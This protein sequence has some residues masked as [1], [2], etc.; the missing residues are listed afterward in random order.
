MNKFKDGAILFAPMDGLTDPEYR[1]LILEHF[2]QWDFICTEFLRLPSSGYLNHAKVIAHIGEAI[3]NSPQSL[4]KNI[5]QILPA[6]KSN[7][8]PSIQVINELNIPHLDLNLGCPVKKVMNHGGGAFWLNNLPALRPVIATIRRNFKGN[9]SAKI[10]PGISDDRNFLSLLELLQ[11]EG[12]D[13]ITI[14]GRLQKQMYQGEANNHYIKQAVAYCQIP[15]IANG[16]ICSPQDIQNTLQQTKCKGV[17]IGRAAIAN[18][19]LLAGSIDLLQFFLLLGQ[20]YQARNLPEEFILKRFKAHARYSLRES[21]CLRAKT[22][23][24]FIEFIR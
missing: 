9:L 11:G 3:F 5:L 7:L 18:P 12:I 6:L 13:C 23:N 15:I 14:H 20:K 1:Q 16:D 10:R 21:K 8:L 2:P 22:I 4:Q 24:E 17:M 19:G